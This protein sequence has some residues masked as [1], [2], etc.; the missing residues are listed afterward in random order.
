ML[1]IYVVIGI[2]MQYVIN[3]ML[4]RTSCVCYI[5]C[6]YIFIY[7]SMSYIGHVSYNGNTIHIDIMLHRTNCE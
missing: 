7:M 4:H 6:T 2:L 5:L 1:T 3:I